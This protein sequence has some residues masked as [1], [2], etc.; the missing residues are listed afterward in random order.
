MKSEEII[1]EMD[2]DS[3]EPEMLEQRELL[4]DIFGHALIE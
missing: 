4:A 1:Q 3:R 2:K